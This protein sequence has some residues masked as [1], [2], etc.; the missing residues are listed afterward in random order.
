MLEIEPVGNYAE[1][2]P[3]RFEE[4]ILRSREISW[5]SFGR[6]IRFYAPGFAHYGNEY[7][8]SL[9]STFPSISIT[10]RFCSLNCGHC[11][12]RILGTMVPAQTPR[13]LMEVCTDIKERGAV[14]CLIS[15]GCIPNG[16][17][18]VGRFIDTIGKIKS[19]LGLTIVVHTGLIDFET[20]KRLREAGVDA[21]SID[22]I[23][24]DET[25][26]EIYN[27]DASTKDY[28][29]SL[30]ALSESGVPFTPHVLAG[31]HYGTLRGELEALRMIAKYRPSALIMIAFFPIKGTRMED[32]KPPS[33]EEI[34]EVL[35]QAR[36]MMPKVPMALGCVRPKGKH[37][38]MTDSLA[39]EAGVNAIAFPTV[40]AIERSK[41]LGLEISFSSVCC[42]QIHEDFRTI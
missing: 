12:G 15:G 33:P 13:R 41:T 29:E 11:E 42:S 9:R 24:S 34:I 30:H 37:R 25:I 21:V 7:L 14:G 6:R 2:L 35:I 18:P 3:E 39:V 17:V 31:L 1:L 27:L 4:K 32:V 26:K 10:G 5:N 20:A 36:F 40:E 19:R 8:R 16:S 22:I 23:G 28:E 38:A